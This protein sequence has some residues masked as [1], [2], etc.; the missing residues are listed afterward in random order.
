MYSALIKLALGTAMAA[1]PALADD[2]YQGLPR[3]FL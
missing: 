3:T 2:G 1:A